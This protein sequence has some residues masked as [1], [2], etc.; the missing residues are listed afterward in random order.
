MN[1]DNNWTGMEPYYNYISRKHSIHVVDDMKEYVR[2]L[3]AH[4]IG[5]QQLIFLL[6][7]RNYG[8]IPN[9]IKRK[10]K[11]GIHFHC[12]RYSGKFDDAI[13]G[14]HIKMLNLCI[15]DANDNQTRLKNKINFIKNLITDSLPQYLSERFFHTQDSKLQRI[16][17][18]KK[19][20]L[21]RKFTCLKNNLLTELLNK[22]QIPKVNH[23]WLVNLSN[24]IL[25]DNV[26]LILGLGPN[27]NFYNNDTPPITEILACIESTITTLSN[28]TCDEL[29]GKL[30]N[31]ITNFKSKIKNKGLNNIQS[32]KQKFIRKFLGNAI[33]E[34]KTFLKQ[35]PNLLVIKADKAN[36]TVIIKKDDYN[37]KML[38]HLSDNTTYEKIKK[39]P[40]NNLQTNVNKSVKL[41]YDKKIIP[42]E[43]K[44]KLSIHNSR[45]PNIY[46]LIK[47]HKHNNPIRPIVNFT[48][49]PTYELSKF[50]SEIIGKI[51]GKSNFHVKDS[52]DFA[53]SITNITVPEDHC[54]VSFDVTSLYTNIPTELALDIIKKKWP[55]IKNHTSINLDDFIHLTEIC[56]NSTYFQYDCFYYKQKHGLAM[57]SPASATIANL[58]MEELEQDRINCCPENIFMYKRYVDDCFLIVPKNR[59]TI[60]LHHFNSYHKR[61]QFTL[62]LESKNNLN[63]LDITVTNDII[64]KKLKQNWYTKPTRGN[65]YLNYNSHTS[66]KYKK[67]V[68]HCLVD[69]CYAFSKDKNLSHNIEKIKRNL[70]D[71][72]YP[73]KFIIDN[74]NNRM[75]K[76]RNN[77]ISNNASSSNI[78]PTTDT[79]REREKKNSYPYL[80]FLAYTRT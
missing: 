1:L 71:N 29:R 44:Q 26:T 47:L 23:D 56:I 8:I 37:E 17:N 5:K 52:W 64:N 61:I 3:H 16:V 36:K 34:T 46:G 7:C 9:F 70:A 15:S 74:I 10:Y 62:E 12:T 57:G 50:I 35:N 60:I 51:V 76:L 14:L 33:H 66:L 6:R 18:K 20:T 27:F 22:N 78:T 59:E 77:N 19:T 30:V 79:E 21:I 40:T 28:D 58:V 75:S 65:R 25:P 73:K 45:S 48:R 24:C 72:N 43:L 4:G 67:N 69:R 55:E 13:L 54:L 63:F 53:N 32:F 42:F 68:V 31:I 80:I 11:T 2:T 39:D 41:L 38:A 49:S